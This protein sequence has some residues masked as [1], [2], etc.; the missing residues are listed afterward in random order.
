M[1]NH[2][3][4]PRH[5]NG[6]KKRRRTHPQGG[7][8]D[9][10]PRHGS[11]SAPS[12][13]QAQRHPEKQRQTHGRQCQQQRG[14]QDLHQRIHH[15]PL[16]KV[17]DSETWRLQPPPRV[18]R[19]PWRQLAQK[20]EVPLSE[21]QVEAVHTPKRIHGL[22]ALVLSCNGPGRIWDLRENQKHQR[23][24]APQHTHPL[25][26]PS[27][28]PHHGQWPCSMRAASSSTEGTSLPAHFSMTTPC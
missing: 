10:G 12:Q 17:A 5:E 19:A 14:R 4:E 1:P 13:G 28:H 6:H 23:G 9:D 18:M 11:I 2:A 15:W 26:Q 24:A 20:T 3:E 21:R 25:G 7:Q 16:S 8:S 22:L 27:Q